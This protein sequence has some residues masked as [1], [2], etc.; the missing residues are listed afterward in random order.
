MD[1]PEIIKIEPSVPLATPR[2]K[3]AAYARV[4]KETERLMHSLSAQVSYYSDLIQKNPEWEY[5]GVYAD[6]FISGTKAENRP[7]LQRLLADCEK[8]LV[9]MILCKSISRLARNTVDLLRIIRHLKELG[10]EVQFEKDN[11]HS[12]SADGEV[13]LTILASFS[14]QESRSIS[15]NCK[16]GIRKRFADGT[17]GTANKHILGYRYDEDAGQYVIIPEEAETVRWMFRMYLEGLSFQQIA[18]RLNAAGICTTLGNMF[19]EGSVHALIFNEIYAGDLRRQKTYTPDPISKVKII[20][21]GKLPQYLFMDCHEAIIDR[22]TYAKVQAEMQR[23]QANLNPTYFFSGK[24]RCECCDNV[25]TRKKGNIRGKTYVSWICRSKK[26]TGMTCTSCNFREDELIRICTAFIGDDYEAR[27]SEMHVDVSGNIRF[28]LTGGEEKVWNNLRL[29][30][31]KH[32]HTVTDAFLGKIICT[33]CGNVYHRCNAKNRW[34]YWKCCGKQKKSIGCDNVTY[35]DYQLRTI[36]AHL[37]ELPE[38]DEKSFTETIDCIEVLPD[39]SL[40]LTDKNGRNKVWQ[41]M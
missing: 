3:V 35:T 4:S 13:M 21:K 16:W 9:D 1:M 2:K 17:I 40:Q 22:E 7:E 20:N 27:I 8:G 11:I 26:E 30:P 32:P 6:S 14:E 18:D 37:L 5:A 19:Q 39:G 28:R 23:R 29:H 36:T 24:I 34:T 41:R 10:I 25:Y 38:F 31:P 33:K 15:E 12:L